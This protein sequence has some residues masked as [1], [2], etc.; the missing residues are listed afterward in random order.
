MLSARLITA[1]KLSVADGPQFVVIRL[2]YFARILVFQ[3][4]KQHPKILGYCWGREVCVCGGEGSSGEGSFRF[5]PLPL[6]LSK[7]LS[8]GKA[9]S[10]PLF[11]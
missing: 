6:I 5:S 10:S 9:V 2:I 3:S 11:S 7:T 4:Q 1:S 8:Q